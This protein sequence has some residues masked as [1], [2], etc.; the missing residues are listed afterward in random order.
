MSSPG[1]LKRSRTAN[2][3]A[4]S[5]KSE[6]NIFRLML[7]SS[8]IRLIYEDEVVQDNPRFGD[9]EEIVRFDLLS[10]KDTHAQYV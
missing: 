2:Y 3:A 4:M 6:R 5:S 8:D 9:D 10:S 1:T 7:R